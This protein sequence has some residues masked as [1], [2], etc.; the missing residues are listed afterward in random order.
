MRTCN[1]NMKGRENW[2]G[3][4]GCGGLRAFFTGRSAAF[5]EKFAPDSPTNYIAGCAFNVKKK[6]DSYVK[7]NRP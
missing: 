1:Y 3:R 6:F 5:K 2:E 7:A 4:V